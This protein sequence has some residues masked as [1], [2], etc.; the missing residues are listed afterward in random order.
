M[1]KSANKDNCIPFIARL[2]HLPQDFW[3]SW[4]LHLA[5]LLSLCAWGCSALR[6]MPYYVL[7]LAGVFPFLLLPAFYGKRVCTYFLAAWAAMLAVA[8]ILWRGLLINGAKLLANRL[9]AIS[10]ASQAYQ[11]DR[12]PVTAAPGQEAACMLF[13]L[14]FCSLLW[15]LVS[16]LLLGR[17]TK[18]MPVAAFTLVC[19]FTAYFGVSAA[20]IWMLLPGLWCLLSLL[21]RHI[22]LA[23][24]GSVIV[25]IVAIAAATL[26][27]F[28]NENARISR[29]DETLRDEMALQTVRYD[30]KSV[31]QEITAPPETTPEEQQQQNGFR[32]AYDLPA[33]KWILVVAVLIAV[34]L[35]LFA[36]AVW[37]DR[38]RKRTERERAGIDDENHAVSVRAMFLYAVRWLQCYGIAPG[39]VNYGAWPAALQG[40]MSEDYQQAFEEILPLWREAAYSDHEMTVRQRED[41]YTFLKRTG[42]EIWEKA[43]WRERLHLKYCCAL[44]REEQV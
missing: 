1:S 6:I 10:E 28:P 18:I 25:G 38:L 23:R 21:P 4:G 34:L 11:Y 43:D 29:L 30:P 26:L 17:Q 7:C 8:A 39:N 3:L 41:A 20:F 31:P 40:T 9:F 12:F 13:V 27:L 37:N 15:A 35:L 22:G 44:R 19:I 2:R 24:Y 14:A 32:F 5:V 16:A 36:P 33:G 42:D